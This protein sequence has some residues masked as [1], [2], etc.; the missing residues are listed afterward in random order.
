MALAFPGQSGTL[1][2]VMAHD[3]FLDA[4]GDQPMRVRIL[5]K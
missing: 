4:F 3:A 2:E 5:E 1:W